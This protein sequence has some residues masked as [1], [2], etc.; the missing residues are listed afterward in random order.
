[1]LT[2]A[3]DDIEC[4]L[5]QMD[6]G[7]NEAAVT[8]AVRVA[9]P[10]LNRNLSGA[11]EKSDPRT[12]EEET[13]ARIV[14]QLGAGLAK[15]L[16]TGIRVLQQQITGESRVLSDSVRRQQ[17]RVEAADKGLIDLK[18]RLEQM[19]G[20]VS[21]QKS[22]GLEAQKQYRHLTAS[23]ASLEE[24]DRRH[25][26]SLT[27]LR[28]EAQGLSRSLNERIE[29]LLGRMG[30]QQEGLSAIES[31]VSEVTPRIAGAVERLDRQG[32]AIGAIQQAQRPWESAIDQLVETLVRLKSS[33]AQAPAAPDRKL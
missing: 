19:T 16:M 7:I 17:E 18:E 29:A 11:E 21:E 32:E 33:P 30:K 31:T 24:A 1:M 20:A 9:S 6:F 23:I 22:V 12:V 15:V 10:E 27:V 5:E 28:Q 4:S 25:A 2:Q 26:S 14:E 13:T 8:A 3:V